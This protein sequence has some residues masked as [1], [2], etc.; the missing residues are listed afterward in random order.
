MQVTKRQLTER[1]LT[2]RHLSFLP[3][4]PPAQKSFKVILQQLLASG[5]MAKSQTS[6]I[7]VESLQIFAL[8]HQESW[9][10]QR[11]QPITMIRIFIIYLVELLLRALWSVA[12]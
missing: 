10:L 3:G 6:R 7:I 12:V 4:L 8:L 2:T 5:K 1:R 11:L 9:L